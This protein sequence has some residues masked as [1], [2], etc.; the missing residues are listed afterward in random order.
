MFIQP[1]KVSGIEDSSP[2]RHPSH[3]TYGV[4]HYAH[5]RIPGTDHYTLKEWKNHGRLYYCLFILDL[6][7][8]IRRNTV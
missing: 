7:L 2:Q 4:T 6:D 8:A 5:Y 1:A 3:I